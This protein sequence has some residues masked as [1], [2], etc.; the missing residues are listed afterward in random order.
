M[1]LCALGC[2]SEPEH[3]PEY[4]PDFGTPRACV[5][6]QSGQISGN[7]ILIEGEAARCAADGMQCALFGLSGCDGGEVLLAQCVG[8]TW[9][10][11]CVPAPDAA[12]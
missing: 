10:L 4:V 6:L 12:P 11:S 3:P 5:E 7:R 8:R 1:V 2:Q 9:L